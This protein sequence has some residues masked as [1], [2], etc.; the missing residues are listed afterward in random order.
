MKK[1]LLPV[2]VFAVSLF[3]YSSAE[4]IVHVEGRYWFTTLDSK[5]TVTD[6]GIIGTEINAADTLGM[7]KSK[8]FWEGRIDLNL[9]SHHLRYAY[10]PLSWDGHKTLIQSVTFKGATY[11]ASTMV[12]SKLDIVYQRLGYRYDIIDMLGNQ[13]GIIFDIKLLGINAQLKDP[14]LSL[15]KS[16]SLTVPVPTIGVGAQIGL[17]FLFSIGAEVTG[18]AYGS[19]SLLDGEAS[20]NF[21]PVPFTTISG[22]YRIFNVEVKDGDNKGSFNLAGPF[23]MVRMGW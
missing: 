20:V 15:D 19:N 17:P 1:I 21:N 8:N 12:D 2:V 18:I 4:A 7:D 6:A 13:L 16:Y 5:V 10:L 9:G 3:A 22:G 11:T 23:L 14:A